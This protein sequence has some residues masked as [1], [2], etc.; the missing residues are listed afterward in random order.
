MRVLL[1]VAVVLCATVLPG[2]GL[3]DGVGLDSPSNVLVDGCV[4]DGSDDGWCEC[5]GQ[6]CLCDGPKGVCGCDTDSS[7]ECFCRGFDEDNNP[8]ED[9]CILNPRDYNFIDGADAACFCT[10]DDCWREDGPDGPVCAAFD[11]DSCQGSLC[12]FF[13]EGGCSAGDDSNYCEC[14]GPS[15]SCNENPIPTCECIDFEGDGSCCFDEGMGEC[16]VLPDNMG[17]DPPPP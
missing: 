13:D 4:A 5:Q 7:D 15:C 12:Q 16:I 6:G 9:R 14:F 8:D 10:E 17:G 11:D 2:C 3:L 1:W